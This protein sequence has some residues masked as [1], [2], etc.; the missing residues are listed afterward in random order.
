MRF[1]YIS[2]RVGWRSRSS[3][4]FR[5]YEMWDMVDSISYI[6]HDWRGTGRYRTGSRYTR[7]RCHLAS[8][9]A[10]S[11]SG[12]GTWDVVLTYHKVPTPWHI[13]LARLVPGL[14]ILCV[15]A[16]QWSPFFGPSCPVRLCFQWFRVVVVIR[17][18]TLPSVGERA[19]GRYRRFIESFTWPQLIINC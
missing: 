1:A 3:C 12:H 7:Y 18:A 6:V 9:M 4:N 14:G 13:I 15:P 11:Q 16:T 17:W 2:E 8:A 19:I 10:G 5:F